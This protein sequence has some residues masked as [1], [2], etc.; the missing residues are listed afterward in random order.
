MVTIEQD[1]QALIAQIIGD[2]DH[3]NC[4]SIREKIDQ[5]IQM[6]QPQIV[7]LDFKQ[8][9]FMDSSGIGLIMGRY[10]L[11]KAMGGEVHVY[12]ASAR[13]LRVLK[14]SGLDR[15]VRFLND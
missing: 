4:V 6:N 15:L 2:I 14:M 8:V 10:K 3:H 5:M 11:V 1:G 7:K 9:G 13:L 12:N